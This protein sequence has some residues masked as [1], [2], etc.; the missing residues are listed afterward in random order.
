MNPELIF[1]IGVAILALA[2]WAVI[3]AFSSSDRTLK[4]AIILGVVGGGLIVIA[5]SMSSQPLS[6]TD[7]PE[8][9]ARLLR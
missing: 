6:I 4:P 7:I 5:T 2:L 1:L 9:I 3:N 8:M